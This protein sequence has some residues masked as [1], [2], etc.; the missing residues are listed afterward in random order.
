MA[1]C[2]VYTFG[3]GNVPFAVDI[4][5]DILSD[6]GS[7]VVV[8][9]LPASSAQREKT[10]MLKPLLRLGD[11]DYALV[12]TDLVAIPSSMLGKRVA[13]LENQRGM[14]VDA[15]DFLL[16]GGSIAPGAPSRG[17]HSFPKYSA[18]SFSYWAGV[19]V[20]P[21]PMQK[22]LLSA[23]RWASSAGSS[24]HLTR[25][26]VQFGQAIPFLP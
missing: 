8:P 6:I 22:T 20:L 16:R 26:P 4:Q 10:P 17:R 24:S 3:G 18:Y 19:K 7:R 23:R 14:I 1:R 11:A 5:A 13:N 25:R 21:H 15:I 12:T 9:L 2:D